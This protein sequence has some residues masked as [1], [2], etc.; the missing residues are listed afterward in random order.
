MKKIFWIVI[1]Q[2]GSIRA[3][4]RAPGLDW[5]EVAVRLTMDIPDELFERPRLEASIKIPQE[6]CVPDVISSEVIVN[7]KKAIER[8]TGLEI[9]LSLDQGK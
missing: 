3:T 1:N 6:A 8:S 9:K 7:A 5:N 2:K 4:K